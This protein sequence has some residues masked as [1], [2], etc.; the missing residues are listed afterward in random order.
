M[1]KKPLDQHHQTAGQ[2]TIE[3]DNL[4]VKSIS[5]FVVALIVIVIGTMVAVN[6]LY[7]FTS[8]QLIQKTE[9][10]VPNR[11]LESV[12]AADK[13]EL[14]EYGELDKQKGVYRLPIE[15]AMKIYVKNNSN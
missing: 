2:N 11:L 7:W 12:N 13:Q 14:S 6:Q 9:L 10:D 1:E 5:W 4:P 3:P 8:S 15:E